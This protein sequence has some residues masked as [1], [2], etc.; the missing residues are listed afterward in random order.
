MRVPP[1]PMPRRSASARRQ[2]AAACKA[3]ADTSARALLFAVVVP[4]TLVLLEAA[5]EE[6]AEARATLA[7][8]IVSEMTFESPL[9]PAAVVSVAS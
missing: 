9:V 3:L 1:V 7:L 8:G 5:A 2:A 6:I 4:A